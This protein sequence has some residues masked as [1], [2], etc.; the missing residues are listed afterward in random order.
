MTSS[1]LQ[2]LLF[3]V[4]LVLA[5]SLSLYGQNTYGTVDGTVVDSQWRGGNRRASHA[6]EHGNAG[7]AH[8]GDGRPGR[9]PVCE[10]DPWCLSVGCGEGRL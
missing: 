7:E 10:R 1:K 6:H 4:V 5:T 3:S 9:L 2:T 8:S